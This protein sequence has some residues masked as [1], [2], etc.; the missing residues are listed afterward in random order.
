MDQ[1]EKGL[2]IS[3]ADALV[4]AKKV[5]IQY[6]TA[7]KLQTSPA[8]QEALDVLAN[9][10]KTMIKQIPGAEGENIDLQ[11]SNS[12]AFY[13]LQIKQGLFPSVSNEKLSGSSIEKE[14]NTDSQAKFSP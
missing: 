13:K 1:I 3:P 7:L 12:V 6:D 4:T 11:A 10:Y 14:A 5:R 2:G 9:C 8:I